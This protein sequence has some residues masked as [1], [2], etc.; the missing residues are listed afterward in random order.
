MKPSWVA[1]TGSSEIVLALVL[2]VATAVLIIVAVRM[3]RPLLGPSASRGLVAILLVAWLL[4]ILTFL[5][6]VIVYGLQAQQVHVTLPSPPNHVTPVTLTCAAVSFAAVAVSTPARLRTRLGNGFL[7]ACL[8]PM[9][10]ELPFDVI[11]IAQTTAIPPLP[12]LY[13]AL[14]FLPLFAIE[15]LTI[16]LAATRPGVRATRWTAVWLAGMFGVFTMWALIGFEYPFDGLP[17]AA[18]IVSK[19]LA[20]A[21]A[22]SLFIRREHLRRDSG[23]QPAPSEHASASKRSA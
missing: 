23:E 17:L 11:V 18:N 14:F 7:C 13:R 3:R 16:A 12:G 6:D 20:F 1:Y 9:V 19:V 4:A 8:A 10:F 22:L 15:V 2:A 5:V 21:T